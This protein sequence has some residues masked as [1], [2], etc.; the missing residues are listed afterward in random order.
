MRHGAARLSLRHPLIIKTMNNALSGIAFQWVYDTLNERRDINEKDG[1]NVDEDCLSMLIEEQYNHPEM[2][3][4]FTHYC[5]E[6]LDFRNLRE[7]A[8]LY[9]GSYESVEEAAD[10]LD[11]TQEALMREYEVYH[12]PYGVYIL[13]RLPKL[14]EL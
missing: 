2:K 14:I 5:E 8:E 11:T 1:Y 13:K 7:F 10:S 12:Y 9:L 4:C 6:H 3:R